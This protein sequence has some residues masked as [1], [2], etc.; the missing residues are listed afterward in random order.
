M[1]LVFERFAVKFGVETK[2]TLVA[3]PVHG[4]ASIADFVGGLETALVNYTETA[5]KSHRRSIT[6]SGNSHVLL[7]T[8]AV[9][10]WRIGH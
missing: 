6:R 3:S 10:G 5:I 7:K 4:F 2:D 1:E 9:S 8:R